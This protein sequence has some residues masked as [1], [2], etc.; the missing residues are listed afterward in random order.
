MPIQSDDLGVFRSAVMA[1]VPEGGGGA[2][3]TAVADGQSNNIFPD[4]SDDNR[5]NG[6]FHLRK[7]FGK[8]NTDD[9]DMLL[10]AGW[11]V[12]KP[13]VDD[14][15]DVTLFETEGW[16]DERT[17]AVLL[18]ESQMV[19]GPR[20]LSRVQDT[21][22][23]GVSVLQLY[24][25][26]PGTSFPS[27]GDTV[28][29]RNPDGG[30]QKVRVLKVTL[31]QAVVFDAAGEYVVNLATC[32]LNKPLDFDVLGAP[33][34]RIPPAS[35][36]AATVF[37]TSPAVG[38]RF[39]G[40][41]PLATPIVLGP[42]P[43]REVTVSGGIYAQLVPAS[44]VPTPVADIYPLVQRPTLSRTA[45]APLTISQAS[46]TLGPNTVL[47]LP[48][49][50]QP[51]LL[52]M[53]HGATAFTTN[54]AGELLQGTTVVGT[55][56]WSGR[57]ITM[58]GNAPSYGAA[59]NTITYTPATVTGATAH[60]SA[61]PVTDA[62]RS[63]AIVAAFEPPPAP[64]SLTVSYMAQGRWYDLVEDGTGKLAGAD[65]SYGA[66]T[67]S[68]VTGSLIGSLGAMPDVD[69]QIIYTWGE[70]D[71]AVQATGMPVRAWAYLPMTEQHTPGTLS[72]A[73]SRSGTNY[74]ASVAANGTVTGPAQ[75]L[76]AERQTD[77]T[78][79]LPF[80]PDT[81][82]DG[83]VTLTYE[84]L[85]DAG[86]F[87]NGGGGAYTLTNAPIK[88]GSARFNVIAVIGGVPTVVRCYSSGTSVFAKGIGVIGT[89]NNTTGAMA[90]SI[91]SLSKTLYKKERVT[92]VPSGGG[93]LLEYTYIKT[94]PEVTSYTLQ[95]DNITTIAYQP[96]TATDPTTEA[97]APNWVIE[98]TAPQGL[99][100][101]TNDAAFTWAGVL[102]FSRDGAL[103]RTW[104][105]ATGA[106]T[107]VGAIDSTGRITLG[108]TAPGA[109]NAVTW[110]NLANDKRGGLDVLQ[111]VFRVPSA[112]ISASPFQLQAGSETASTNSGGTLSGDFV[113]DVDGQ[114]G[115]VTWAVTGLGPLDGQGTPVRAD[116]ITYNAI[117]L[118][119]VPL[120]ADLLGVDTTGLAADG[121]AVIYR[122]GGSVVVH[123]TDTL[124]LPNPAVRDNAYSLGRARVASVVV[125][126]AVGTRL[127]GTLYQVN[128]NT[129]HITIP[130]ASNLTPYAQ[131][132]SVEHRVQDELQVLSA[133][134]SGKLQLA[135]AL[136]H[137]FPL[138]SYVSSKLRQG[139]R[140]ARVFGYADRT[141]WLNTWQA[142]FNGSDIGTASF[143][144]IDHPIQTTNRG[145]ITERWAAIFINTTEVRVV[146][147]HVGQVLPVAAIAGAIS[148]INPQTGVPYFTIPAA[149]WGG[150]W[151]VGSVLLFETQACGAPAWITRSTLP[152]GTEV[153]DD[154]AII[155]YIS[156]VDT[157]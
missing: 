148:A 1:D 119:Y 72:I 132:L 82:P 154:S 135:G 144:S 91:G 106:A 151:S 102:H 124:V 97:I 152:G 118:Q 42:T 65:S 48:T 80:S 68:F 46:V 14:A 120:D 133:D 155:A 84:S 39:H 134:I 62:T 5:A 7:V 98:A 74:A 63:T 131:P 112:P 57:V 103:F 51:G 83:P 108:T 85:A 104:N 73:W 11:V 87:T 86:A 8:A 16:F 107:N 35:N 143:N 2:T 70:A 67:L 24:S 15:V 22:Y 40:V 79:L 142:T 94:T 153:L 123:H 111:G 71:S 116:E 141:T 130:A 121:K 81:L 54:N 127:P 10:G 92:S 55:V 3:G 28:V 137:N 43:I 122:A 25:P 60:S 125:R 6:A 37:S 147:E 136:S 52:S 96:D 32:D 66:G 9:Q 64:G 59:T 115:I 149:G 41:K 12:L 34:Q 30:E 150:G 156:N 109:S 140:F 88:P 49:A 4:I 27:A 18:V 38:A 78:Y 105:P 61:W 23:A 19:K 129:G 47:R 56:D 128:R 50:A 29:L 44:T 110:N 33:V 89:I 101:V 139:D 77:G 20:L 95:L 31:S 99:E 117:Y 100:V 53:N 157:P 36:V 45:Q 58:S 146:G 126:D 76:A 145:A 26:A 90:L 75:V 69:S 13:P 113:G 17:A 21:H 114:R 93:T 138:G